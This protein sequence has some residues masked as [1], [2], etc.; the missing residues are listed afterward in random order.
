M[1][2]NQRPDV[3]LYLSQWFMLGWKGGEGRHEASGGRK[4][5]ICATADRNSPSCVLGLGLDG[6]IVR[7][8][9][10]QISSR[11]CAETELDTSLIKELCGDRPFLRVGA[12]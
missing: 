7:T 5:L 9:Q 12:F 8:S 3:A 11:V 4:P 2:L 1:A 6:R 10:W